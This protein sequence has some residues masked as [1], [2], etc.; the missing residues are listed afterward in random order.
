MVTEVGSGL[1]SASDALT[2]IGQLEKVLSDSVPEMSREALA[3]FKPAVG[4]QVMVRS[5]GMRLPVQAIMPSGE[6][7][8]LHR[9]P[10]AL[11][12]WNNR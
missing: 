12:A 2:R 1:Y 9:P 11:V 3:S 4:Q 7:R 5:M 6:V 10:S 8:A